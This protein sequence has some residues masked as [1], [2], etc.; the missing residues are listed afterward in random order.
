MANFMA[1]KSVLADEELAPEHRLARS[2]SWPHLIAL[3]VGA[4]VGTGILTLIGVGAAKARI[5]EE[6]WYRGGAETLI[7]GGSAAGLAFLV[8]VMLRGIVGPG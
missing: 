6:S 2:L 7:V 1:K 8:G 3:G 4:I 5:V